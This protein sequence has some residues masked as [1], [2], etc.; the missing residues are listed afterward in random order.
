MTKARRDESFGTLL[1]QAAREALAYERGELRDVRVTHAK[2]T[3]R[4]V[5]VVPPP[6]Y[7][8]GDVRR[9]RGELGLSQA[10]FAKLLGASASTVRA[11]ERGVRE[12][13]EMARR[14]IALAERE[15]QVFEEDL[16]P[17]ASENGRDR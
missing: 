3:A 10:V 14:L 6:E 5:D 16:V 11:W 17:A 1:I 7:R 12:P 2:V 9:V 4:D 8:E 15:P 13:S